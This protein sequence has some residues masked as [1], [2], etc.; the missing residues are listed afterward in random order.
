VNY[1]NVFKFIYD[2]GYTGLLGMEHGKS[3]P[4]KEGELALIQ[5]YRE[6]DDFVP[7]AK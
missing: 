3:L 6:A 1:K 4:G 2:R 5:A 7:A